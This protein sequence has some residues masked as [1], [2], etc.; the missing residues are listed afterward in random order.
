M[1]TVGNRY[2]KALLDLAVRSHSVDTYR[3]QLLSVS[4]IYQ[5]ENALRTF[6]LSPHYELTTKRRLL[7]RVFDGKIRKNILY[8]LLLLLDKGRIEFLPD[9]SSAYA[10][11]ADEYQN[12]LNITVTTALP[13]T[14]AQIDRI[15]EQF[16]NVCHGSSVKMT[17]QTD[18]SLIG[19]VKVAIGDR[20]YDGTVKG[21]LL[22]MKSALAGQ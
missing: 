9:V 1:S 4:Q 11:L 13:L 6:L 14:Q 8:L 17:V 18:R 7:S 16:R 2:A 3:N 19:G 5:T 21:K 22:K 10:R 20:A 12:I 15:G